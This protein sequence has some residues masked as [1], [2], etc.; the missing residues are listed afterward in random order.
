MHLLKES[1]YHCM[2]VGLLAIQK[3]LK[4]Q[5]REMVFW[6]NHSLFVWIERI[7]KFFELGPL[8]TKIKHNLAHLVLSG[9]NSQKISPYSTLQYCIFMFLLS[10]VCNR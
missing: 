1:I 6:P 3:F 2:L 4:G 10:G 5:Y 7:W 9:P 8:I